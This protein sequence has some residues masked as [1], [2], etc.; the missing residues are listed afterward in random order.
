[1]ILLVKKSWVGSISGLIEKESFES[2]QKKQKN[3]LGTFF[4]FKDAI[5]IGLICGVIGQLGDFTESMLKRDVGI[6]D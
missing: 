5:A 4:E 2:F 3:L 1:M 6:K